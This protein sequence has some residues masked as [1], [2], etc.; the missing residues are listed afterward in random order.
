MITE[1]FA[2]Q[3]KKIEASEISIIAVRVSDELEKLDLL[4]S[5][6]V[7]SVDGEMIRV[8]LRF[9]DPISISKGE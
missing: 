6:T 1:D 7:T 9:T 8:R 4:E 2:K 5:W 3:L